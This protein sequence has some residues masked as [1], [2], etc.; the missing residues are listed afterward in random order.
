MCCVL[1]MRHGKQ[2]LPEKINTFCSA[3][4]PTG[5]WWF[6]W[7][8][9]VYS[10]QVKRQ[11]SR[12][13]YLFNLPSHPSINSRSLFLIIQSPT[14]HS[15]YP[16]LGGIDTLEMQLPGLSE[17]KMFSYLGKFKQTLSLILNVMRA[18]KLLS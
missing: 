15:G 8:E 6:I 12:Q 2:I 4:P 14:C 5:H 1:L 17:L 10:D 16:S 18:V 3:V 11:R 9:R 13:T 7:S